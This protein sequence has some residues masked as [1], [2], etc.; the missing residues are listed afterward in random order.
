[1][2][3]VLTFRHEP[4]RDAA[5]A[6]VARKTSEQEYRVMS[7][8]LG[9][10]RDQLVKLTTE[11]EFRC[12]QLAVK[13]TESSLKTGIADESRRKACSWSSLTP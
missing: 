6:A 8:A 11:L 4:N 9:R 13:A 5:P 3:N 1:M 10:L 7:D 12:G 2:S